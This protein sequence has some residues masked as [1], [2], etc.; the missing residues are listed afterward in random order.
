M[1]TGSP[2]EQLPSSREVR[3]GSKSFFFDVERNDRGVYVRLT[4]VHLYCII[5]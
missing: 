1:L 2:Q 4:E 3:A 5:I